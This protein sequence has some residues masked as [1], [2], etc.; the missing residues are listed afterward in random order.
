M[1]NNL[2]PVF[3]KHSAFKGTKEEYQAAVWKSAKELLEF[4]A[5]ARPDGDSYRMFM[6]TDMSPQDVGRAVDYLVQNK[7]S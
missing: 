7:P 6:N 4:S 2:K 1:T 3:E 5:P